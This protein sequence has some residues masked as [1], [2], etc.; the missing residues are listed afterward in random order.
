MVFPAHNNAMRLHCKGTWLLSH[1]SLNHEINIPLHAIHV[2]KYSLDLLGPWK[3]W[4]SFWERL[5]P[6]SL[7]RLGRSPWVLQTSQKGLRGKKSSMHDFAYLFWH[8]P[9][10]YNNAISSFRAHDIYIYTESA[11]PNCINVILPPN[12]FPHC[13]SLRI[14]K[15]I[16]SRTASNH[17]WIPLMPYVCFDILYLL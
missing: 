14:L 8:I 5:H 2:K 9:A 10:L 12:I 1:T 16:F 13:Q 7:W 17:P 3:K 15:I 6:L 11:V 4:R